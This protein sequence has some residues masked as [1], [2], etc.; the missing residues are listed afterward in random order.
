MSSYKYLLLI[1]ISLIVL[2]CSSSKKEEIKDYEHLRYFPQGSTEKQEYYKLHLAENPSDDHAWKQRSIAFNKRGDIDTG[3]AYLQKAVD[4][5]PEGHIGYRGYVKLYMMHDYDDAL[6]DFKTLLKISSDQNPVAWGEN[7][8]KLIGLTFLLEGNYDSALTYLERGIKLTTA[9]FGA[10]YVETNAF[11]YQAYAQFYLKDFESALATL[12]SVL[13][14]DNRYP[15]AHFLRAKVYYSQG[16]ISQ[17]K[18]SIE[19]ADKLY[20]KYKSETNAYYEV[21]FQ[22]YQSQIDDLMGRINIIK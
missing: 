5:N 9:E 22:L 2:S 3:M 7:L 15:E 6:E 10:D 14:M 13:E 21:P 19:T 20:R 4:L 11:L 18:E 16:K 17:A 12:S 1:L 8:H